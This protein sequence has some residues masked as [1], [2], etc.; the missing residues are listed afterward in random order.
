M[1]SHGIDNLIGRKKSASDRL[2][3]APIRVLYSFPLKLGADRICTTAWYQ[4]DGLAAAG[5][6]VTVFPAAISRPL[7]SNVKVRPT[8]ARGKFR[9]PNRL[10]G[11]M[12]YARLH[13]WI[14]SCRIEKM[15]G[16]IDIIHTWPLGALR[17]LKTA[18]R[19]GIP[20]VLER[21]NAHTRFAYEVV[22]KECERLGI[23]MPAGHEHAFNADYLRREE[24]EYQL[25]DHLL[26][27]SDFVAGTFAE[28]GFAKERLARHQYGFDEKLFFAGQQNAKPDRGL[29][30]IFVGGCAPRKG[31]HY[32][33]E[34]WLKSS[35]HEKGTFFIA[36]EFIP[37][38]AEKLSA[39]L[40]HP[41]V[42]RL[43]HRSDVAELMRQSDVFILPTIEEGSA[44]VTLEARGCG[45]VLLVSDASG[46]VCKHEENALMHVARDVETLTKQLT[47]L[48]KDRALLK[49]L[50]TA[51]LATAHEITWVAAGQKLLSVYKQI[52]ERTQPQSDDAAV[53]VCHARSNLHGID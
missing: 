39:Q 7:S 47:M 36:G 12:N 17:T 8:L 33:L 51:S 46:A 4:V 1:N 44:L 6:E 52:L 43:G 11:R 35:A 42:K 30:M 24:E 31:L 5:A 16:Q 15:A 45:C 41:S 29:K 48:D 2:P 20:T 14:V 21:P 40:A 10:L 13:D 37:G 23:S 38:Y 19:L 25:T 49:R 3:G 9:V 32:A 26:C 34:A 22:E 28:M 18:R 50:R 53:A 27:P